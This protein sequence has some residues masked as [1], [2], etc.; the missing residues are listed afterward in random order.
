MKF[1]NFGGWDP[2]LS[3]KVTFAEYIWIDGSGTNLRSKTKIINSEIKS[4]DDLDWWTFDGSSCEMAT[5]TQSEI[6]LKPVIFVKDP[7][8]KENSILVMC[9][10]YLPDKE[11]PARC[12]FRY[13]CN[14]IMEEAKD[15]EPW[16][17]IEQEF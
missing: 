15:H 10:T 3:G 8:R 11:T 5:T 9:E 16:F 12:N 4:I 6:W 17:G 1:F 14:K 2:L 13:L 7:I